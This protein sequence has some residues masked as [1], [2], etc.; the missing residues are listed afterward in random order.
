MI[1]NFHAALLHLRP[2]DERLSEAMQFL[3]EKSN[4]FKSIFLNYFGIHHQDLYEDCFAESILIIH[5]SNTKRENISHEKSKFYIW[6]VL[7]HKTLSILKRQRRESEILKRAEASNAQV[8]ALDDPT[9]D[10]PRRTYD[11]LPK[12][13]SSTL[14]I[15]LSRA[16][17]LDWED[18]DR[19]DLDALAAHIEQIDAV[20]FP[21][22]MDQVAPQGKKGL[23]QA[24][25]HLK[26]IFL[27]GVTLDQL[28][29][30]E[31]RKTPESTEKQIH[32]RLHQKYCRYREK[33]LHLL[34]ALKE[35]CKT[36]NFT[37]KKIQ[38]YPLPAPPPE[39]RGCAQDLLARGR[40]TCTDLRLLVPLGYTFCHVLGHLRGGKLSAG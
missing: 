8:E 20:L 40:L 18:L 4:D 21:A 32:D 22:L 14:P 11:E 38:K 28:R 3:Q 12:T 30:E 9:P 6:T 34:A 29:E 37:Y 27:E 2:E 39:L 23:Q 33:F 24:H 5:N 25:G 10:E 31:Q 19:D 35:I 1:D 13:P 16:L 36:N 17:G 26:R 15:W 7:K